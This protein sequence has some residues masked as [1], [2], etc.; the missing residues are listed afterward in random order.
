VLG[1]QGVQLTDFALAGGAASP[2]VFRRGAEL[3]ATWA[4]RSAGPR[5]PWLRQLDGAGRF[6]GDAV[7]L[8]PDTTQAYRGAVRAR[9]ARPAVDRLLFQ[10][11]GGPYTNFFTIVDFDGHELMPPVAARNR[12]DR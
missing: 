5:Q 2:R 1:T 6:V 10:R 8:M 4:D 3:W 12:P 11:T 9:R 7:A